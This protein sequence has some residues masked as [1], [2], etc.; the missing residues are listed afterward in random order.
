M[1]RT[2]PGTIG[3]D[4]QP[5]DLQDRLATQGASSATLH[6]RNVLWL[7]TI[8]AVIY[9]LAVFVF[10]LVGAVFGDEGGSWDE[11]LLVAVANFAFVWVVAL[12]FTAV[13]RRFR[14]H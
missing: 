2:G 4:R 1:R 8:T 3:Q 12:I 7:P 14:K 10:A 6:R 9:G 5:L 13:I 11:A